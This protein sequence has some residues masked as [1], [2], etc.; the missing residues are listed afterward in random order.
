LKAK[1]NFFPIKILVLI[2]LLLVLVLQKA[3]AQDEPVTIA[4]TPF[5]VNAPEDMQY[6]KSG[7]Q[8]MLES[9]LSQ[10]ENVVVISDEKITEAMEGIQEPIDEDE[11]REIG[12][13]LSADYVLI[14]SL[15]V[16]G[17][18]ASL[19]ARL[20]DSANEKETFAFFDQSEN[21][22]DLVPKI[23]TFAVDINA[24][25]TGAATTAVAAA[26]PKTA[27]AGN[28][29]QAHPEKMTDNPI[30]AETDQAGKTMPADTT[31]GVL[32]TDFWKS[33]TYKINIR[34]MALGDVDGDGKIETVVVTRNH[35]FIFRNE[36]NKFYKIGEIKM[37]SSMQFVGVDVGDING[38]HIDEIFI[39]G[40]TPQKTGVSSFVLEYD[41]KD[42]RK[43]TDKNHLLYRIVHLEGQPPLLFGQNFKPREETANAIFHMHS[44][45]SS[46][47]PGENVI[48]QNTINLLGFC[49]GDVMNLGANG[50][51][52][53][54]F[55]DRLKVFNENGLEEWDGSEALGGNT[56]N[57]SK[58]RTGKGDE[59][60]QYLP[61]RVLLKDLDQDGK[62]DV[63]AVKNYEIAGR[64]LR[65]FRMFTDFHIASLSWDGLGMR[66]NWQTPKTS[67]YMRDYAI[68]DF[69]NDGKDELVGA[70]V[71]KEGRVIG[72][73]PKS[74]IVSYE[75]A[76]Q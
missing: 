75:I 52:A 26:T 40:L 57:F 71:L 22:D 41:G 34:G 29:A 63:I 59:E 53:Y 50:V 56:L 27:V 55:S 32:S 73:T 74:T 49:Y 35:V 60:F 76:G 61:M 6:L 5:T 47:E 30:Q 51:V 3:S 38:N 21:I 36:A 28:D 24:K 69:D 70:I 8:D 33:R 14:G 72:V 10:D 23:N 44:S 65:D 11:A 16:F 15:T 54:N 42:Y 45:G 1:I 4:I 64:A 58:G 19:D 43:I 68:G 7:I 62:Q 66:S 18:S 2:T 9:R 67:G 39:S 48:A 20:V 13:R 12:Q 25:M 37:S 31:G 46:Y 17:S